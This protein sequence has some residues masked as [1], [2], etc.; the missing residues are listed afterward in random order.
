[1]VTTPPPLPGRDRRRKSRGYTLVEVT[2]VV[3]LLGIVSLVAP[4]LF[5]Q[6]TRFI[7]MSRAQYE[8]QRDSK[9]ALATI[10]RSLRQ[11]EASTISITNN[12]GQPP[13]SKITFEKYV[14]DTTSRTITF[15]QA[16]DK[17]YMQDENGTR[18]VC[19][20][21]RYIAFTYPRTDDDNILSVSITME[22]ATF[23]GRTK[24]LQLAVE[25]VRI[26]NN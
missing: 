15:Y 17:L 21:L 11:A 18:V 22:K 16:A 20:N 13:Y 2:I 25:K 12:T 6:V 9:T 24:A 23:Q 1:V 7:R 4:R 14:S 8:I 10:N 19:E 3:A 26:M 5:L